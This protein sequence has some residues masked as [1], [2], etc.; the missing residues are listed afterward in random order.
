MSTNTP[1]H[2]TP[3]QGAGEHSLGHSA[4]PVVVYEVTGTV[5]WLDTDLDRIVVGV[6]DTDGHAGMFLGR[7]VTVDVE[8]ARLNGVTAEGLVPGTEVRVKTHL[9]RSLGAELPEM[10]TAASISA[11]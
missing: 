1:Q 3:N 4:N 11:V 10:L 9:P 8:A 5:R 6:H 2:G 7:D